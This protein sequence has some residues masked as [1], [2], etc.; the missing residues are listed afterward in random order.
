MTGYHANDRERCERFINEKSYIIDSAEDTD[1]LG[2]GMYFWDNMSQAE[3]W[4][5][6]KKK[7][8]IVSAELNL[9]CVLDLTQKEIADQMAEL[10]KM[11]PEAF[12]QK[13]IIVYGCL[14]ELLGIRLN[15]LFESFAELKSNFNV[16]K[17]Q[18]S[19]PRKAESEFLKKTKLT[20][21]TVSIYCAK[22]AAPIGERK[23]CKK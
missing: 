11:I 22:T 6:T 10:Y 1:Y 23:W 9:D 4:L 17:A 8:A 2:R 21:Q 14:D 16:V 20:S 13:Y 18:R 15:I 5:K 7:D 12:I 19:Y 3:W